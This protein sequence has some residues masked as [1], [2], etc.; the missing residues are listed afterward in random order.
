MTVITFPIRK[1]IED[2]VVGKLLDDVMSLV[3][4]T[5]EY[6]DSI[7]HRAY[8]RRDLNGACVAMQLTTK[9]LAMAT[10]VTIGRAWVDDGMPSANAGEA[11]S[12]FSI[13]AANWPSDMALGLRV[14]CDRV[15][16][17]TPA[18]AAAKQRLEQAIASDPGARAG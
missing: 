16:T 5:S 15:D 11:L 10:V 14:F 13:A 17:L 12:K 6:L 3:Q 7:G 4:D 9:L 8:A 18:V 2:D 1:R